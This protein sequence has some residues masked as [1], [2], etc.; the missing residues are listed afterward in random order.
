M[1]WPEEWFAKALRNFEPFVL[2]NNNL[3]EKLLSSLESPTIFDESF[4]V[5]LVPSFS[6]DF[7]LLSWEKC[8]RCEKSKIVSFASSVM[9]TF[10]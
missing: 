6:P 5:T 10:V 9:K 7:N 4:K 2:V 3:C 1:I 8:F